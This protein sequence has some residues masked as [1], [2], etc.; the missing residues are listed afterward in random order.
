M[1]AL[2]RGDKPE[3]LSEQKALDL[4]K[5][6]LNTKN[7][8]WSHDSIKTALMESSSEKCAYCECSLA[9]ESNYMEVE[10]FEHKDKYPEKVV[11]WNNLLPACKRC[12]VAKGTHDVNDEP[13]INPY[14]LNPKDHLYFNFYRLKSLS[15]L[16]KKTIEVADLNNSDRV[17]S[18]RIQIGEALAKGIESALDR[19][20]FFIENR[21]AG[22]RNKLVGS[23]KSLLNECQPDAQYA[24]LSATVL[25]SDDDFVELI[26][27]L[28]VEL[29]WTEEHESLWVAAKKISLHRS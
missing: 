28:K 24:A 21:I 26:E 20:E 25:T 13:I 23:V 3:Y 2:N 16:G 6:F 1:I 18:A 4:T 17:V 8:V 29:L 9:I 22:R 7:S 10:H 11:E 27:Q 12:N 19:F 5:E 15:L 14:V